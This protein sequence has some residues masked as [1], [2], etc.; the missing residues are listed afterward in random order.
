MEE[1]LRLSMKRVAAVLLTVLVV[2][3]ISPQA[4]GT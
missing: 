3:S 2:L 1:H 4:A